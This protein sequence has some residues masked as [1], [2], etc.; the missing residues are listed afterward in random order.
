VHDR[1]AYHL[2]RLVI[3]PDDAVKNG[4]KNETH[5][6]A[7]Q[8]ISQDMSAK[9]IMMK[10]SLYTLAFLL[11]CLTG[12]ALAAP[13]SAPTGVCI[14]STE[15]VECAAPT[16]NTT[17]PS[18]PT[19][20]NTAG[21]FPGTNLK[22]RPGF[23]VASSEN[24]S[25]ATIESR[26]QQLFTASP[27]RKV[28]YRP[29]GI[30]GGVLRRLGW[31]RF[32][33]NTNVRPETPQDHRDPAYDWSLLDEIFTIN[34]VRNEGALVAIAVGDIGWGSRRVP[35][36]LANA[37]YNGTFNSA[38]AGTDIR[39][40]PK[41]YRYTDTGA[42][43]PIVEEYVYFQQ[44]LHDHLVATGNIDKVMNVQAG[45]TFV[46]ASAELPADYNGD[47]FKRGVGIRNSK[48]AAIWA[49]SQI[50]VYF[51]S[52]V[53][54]RRTTDWE[55]MDDPLAGITHPD[56]HLTN[57][58][59]LF[60]DNRFKNL[61][62]VHQADTRPLMQATEGSG[63]EANTYF[64]PGVPNPWG[65]SNQTVPQTPSHVLWALSGPPKAV[66]KDS[67]LG[68]AGDDPSGIAPIHTVIVEW[69]RSWQPLSPSISD[70]HTAIDTFGPPGTFAFP[71]LP[72]GYAP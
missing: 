61:A 5:S 40:T 2:I 45:E 72:P 13:P 20:N 62:G 7:N 64:A 67:G 23:V 70:W 10:R 59:T 57:T 27:N 42:T 54:G 71:Y 15:G 39:D 53:G 60:G 9:Y 49:K 29:P 12:A 66:S 34:A 28:S 36:W 30:Y 6:V 31:H 24:E 52:I 35:G 25:P 37:P 18:S 1:A 4:M 3:K 56:M 38:A 33:V 68:Q 17:A 63:Q 48:T 11:A 44:A 14:Q 51:S 58:S 50:P 46:A 47:N 19:D 26:W 41:Y 55:Y 8:P 69:G 22:F 65:Y 21:L 32:Y 16:G 43:P